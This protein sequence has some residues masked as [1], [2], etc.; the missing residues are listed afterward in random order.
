MLLARHPAMAG[1][2]RSDVEQD[3]QAPAPPTPAPGRSSWEVTRGPEHGGGT[4]HTSPCQI[5]SLLT[6]RLHAMVVS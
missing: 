3:V 2:G 5:Q 4:P 1:P 6:G